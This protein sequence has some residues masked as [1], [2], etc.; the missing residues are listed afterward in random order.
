MAVETEFVPTSWSL[1]D[2]FPAY[3]SPE[4]RAA[5]DDLNARLSAFEE[6]RVSLTPDLSEAHPAV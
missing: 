2:L 5:V 4:T 3:D 1:D 6:V